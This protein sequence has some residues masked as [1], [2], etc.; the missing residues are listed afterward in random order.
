MQRRL[1]RC[2]AEHRCEPAFRKPDDVG[3]FCNRHAVVTAAFDTEKQLVH[4]RLRQPAI[5]LF[6]RRSGN[7]EETGNDAANKAFR[8][9]RMFRRLGEF[10]DE[11]SSQCF[12]RADI[13][14]LDR[15]AQGCHRR[16]T[17]DRWRQET[18][19][20]VLVDMQIEVRKP[21]R[22]I[23][24]RPHRNTGRHIDRPRHGAGMLSELA[25]AVG[26]ADARRDIVEKYHDTW[27]GGQVITLRA[28]LALCLPESAD[29]PVQLA[30]F[31]RR[32]DADPFR[33]PGHGVPETQCGYR[34][35]VEP[36]L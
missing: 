15:A 26:N 24:A 36:R 2:L 18:Q 29:E 25:V 6:R 11:Q 12:D 17:A 16:R 20:T 7:I 23:A 30:P 35:V 31:D 5:Y 19:Q 3:H 14:Y 21:V 22:S 13:L 34:S 1:A 33:V 10:I 9:D 28:H 27:I 8:I 4:L 32:S